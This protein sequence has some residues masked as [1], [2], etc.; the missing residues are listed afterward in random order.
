MVFKKI[1]KKIGFVNYVIVL[2]QKENIKDVH[3]VWEEEELWNPQ[4]FQLTQIFSMKP[5]LS[6]LNFNKIVVFLVI[7]MIN[8]NIVIINLINSIYFIK[9]D[10]N[11][12][13]FDDS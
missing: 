13:G 1:P 8:N 7:K 6:I 9:V 12:A 4:T 3:F 11:K 2:D 5:I 10:N